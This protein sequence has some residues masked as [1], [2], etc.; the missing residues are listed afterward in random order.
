MRPSK[1]LLSGADDAIRPSFGSAPVALSH[2]G[3]KRALLSAI[4]IASL[5]FAARAATNSQQLAGAAHA[6]ASA[7]NG[8][9]S[10]MSGELFRV[11]TGIDLIHVPYRGGVRA[12]TDLLSRQVQIYFATMAVSL[13]PIRAGKVRAL[14][15]TTAKRSEALPDIPTVAEFLPGYETIGAASAL[16]KIRPPRSS[17]RSTGRSITASR[18]RKSRSVLPT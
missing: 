14:A 11:M 17:T 6:G 9:T 3:L 12:T 2:G 15:V 13:E 8:S 10:H 7:G 4:F 1:H 18:I 16:P 5:T